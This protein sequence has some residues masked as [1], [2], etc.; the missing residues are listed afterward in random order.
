MTARI[1]SVTTARFAVIAGAAIAS[2]GFALPE[3]GA[4]NV[5]IQFSGHLAG[6]GVS[7]NGVGIS[8]DGR[9]VVGSSRG[10]SSLPE[11]AI[12]WDTWAGSGPSAITGL[13]QLPGGQNRSSA[14]AVNADG[15]VVVGRAWSGTAPFE[16]YRW[17]SAS[18]MV[19]I[20][21]FAGGVANQ[22]S[23]WSVSADGSVV[24]GSGFA[25]D[26]S[27]AYAWTQTGGFEQVD[28][29]PGGAFSESRVISGDAR[30]MGVNSSGGS[31]GGLRPS[32][33][34]RE[35]NTHVT[36]IPN[37]P[38]MTV[39]SIYG[40]A[41]DGTA[42]AGS[43]TF[44]DGINSYS[45]PYHWTADGGTQSLGILGFVDTGASIVRQAEAFA[46]SADGRVVVG[47]STNEGRF[48]E[49][50][51]W[52]AENGMRSLEDVVRDAGIDLGDWWLERA[53]GVSA[54]GNV[55]TGFATN[56]NIGAGLG[57]QAFV[58]VIPAPG[59]ASVLALGLAAAVRRRRR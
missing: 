53:T 46:M 18:G 31:L 24:V 5:S 13:G 45:T 11:E 47:S 9:Y 25:P 59:T 19:G 44:N 10:P 28:P 54:D 23:A 26:G 35:T 52:D 38:G 58:I 12:L 4:N 3:A 56:Q 2:V 14:A 50:F 6:N 41:D 7:T 36:I 20:G 57:T 37:G 1:S 22:S 32:I 15:S 48:F 51:I 30:L 16:S 33:Y 27:R 29:I 43:G 42:A 34:S 17:T 40:L 8:R 49:A 55:I 21:D 39:S